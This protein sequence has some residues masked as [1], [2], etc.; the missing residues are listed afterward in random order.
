MYAHTEVVYIRES[1][2]AESKKPFFKILVNLLHTP[3][4]L[5]CHLTALCD[6]FNY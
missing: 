5:F 6:E 3:F 4:I 1:E 2:G